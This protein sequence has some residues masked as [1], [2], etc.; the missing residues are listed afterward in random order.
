MFNKRYG[1]DGQPI[2][3]NKSKTPL[4]KPIKN[5]PKKNINSVGPPGP[6][7]LQ[8]PPG[9]QGLQGLQGPAGSTVLKN[10]NFTE[11]LTDV[12]DVQDDDVVLSISSIKETT[13]VLP[14][15]D[16]G[17]LIWIIPCAN[18]DD[19]IIHLKIR[20]G[21]KLLLTY[22]DIKRGRNI[23]LIAGGGYWTRAN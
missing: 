3:S 13:I 14:K 4:T 20:D 22:P 2:L 5:K 19:L 21:D 12:Y 9:P 18:Y 7:G 17:R 11:I 8:G 6:Q 23:I 16:P 15:S 10:I 1:H